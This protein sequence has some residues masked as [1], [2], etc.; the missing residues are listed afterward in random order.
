MTSVTIVGAGLAGC[1]CAWQLAEQ[2]IEVRL[3]EQ[4]PVRTTPAHATDL[5][6]ELV[7]SNSLRASS[8]ANAVGTLKQELLACHSLI[9]RMANE[10]RVPAGGAVAVDRDAFARSVTHAIST[11]PRIAVTREH[12]ST[13]P[14]DRPCVIATG[15]LTSDDLADDLAHHIGSSA[16]RYYDAIAPI[17]SADS[18]DETVV[19]R[20]SRYDRSDE[21]E[22]VD[23]GADTGAYVNCPMDREQ[24]EAFVAA[25][26]EADQLA[27]REFEETP[28][29]EGCL[30]IEVMASRGAMTLAF[31]PMKPVGLIDPRTGRRPFAVVQLR[32][33]NA[34]ATAYNM[35]GFQTRLRR[36]EQDRVFRMI[37]GL[38][39]TEFLRWGSMHRN[40]F[41]D[42]PRVLDASLQLRSLPGV[43]LAGQITGVEGYV[44]SCACGLLCGRMLADQLLGREVRRPPPTTT[45]GGLLGHLARQDGPFQPSNITW[46]NVPPLPGR[47]K[48]TERKAAMA[49]RALRDLEKMY[50]QPTGENE[51]S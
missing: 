4:R 20:Q 23:A 27:P 15:P 2:G 28:C 9:M 16:L 47:W 50:M 49:K 51:V 13:I 18:I 5:L 42:A 44:E 35:V 32:A 6:A 25:L 29:F 45:L 39:H 19:F 12:C 22:N 8:V 21:C 11:H 31:G 41:V 10:H 24:Y 14:T 17:V 48:K 37:P 46:A 30:P 1:E 26:L 34:S 40:T 43:H 38:S 7:C 36:P 33:E 3:V